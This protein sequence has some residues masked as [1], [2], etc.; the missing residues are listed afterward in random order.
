MYGVTRGPAVGG[1]EGE[2]SWP[3]EV[4]AAGLCGLGNTDGSRGVETEGNR[5]GSCDRGAEPVTCQGRTPAGGTCGPARGGDIARVGNPDERDELPCGR[6]AAEGTASCAATGGVSESGGTAR[7]RR[8]AAE[9]ASGDWPLRCDAKHVASA[10]HTASARAV[11][12]RG[13]CRGDRVMAW[14][15]GHGD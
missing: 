2:K 5:T 7:Q 13:A 14:S 8:A 15:K 9:V 3:G 12:A 6:P 1:F 11:L 10:R 4:T